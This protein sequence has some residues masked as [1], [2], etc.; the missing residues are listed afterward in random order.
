MK[1]IRQFAI[2]LLCAA[3]TGACA[4]AGGVAGLAGAARTINLERAIDLALSNNR[5][6]AITALDTDSASI[7]VDNARSVFAV[8]ARPEVSFNTAS[9]NGGSSTV[10]FN[11]SKRFETGTEVSSRITREELDGVEGARERLVV[12]VSQPLFRFSGRLVNEEPLVQARSNLVRAKRQL[13]SQKQDLVVDVVREYENIIRLEK[14]VEA[15]VRSHERSRTLYKS[16]KAKETLGRASRVDTLRVDLQRGQSLSRLESDRER[17]ESARRTFAE[18]LGFEPRTQ[19]RLAPTI[20]LNLDVPPLEQTVRV[21]LANRLDYAQALQDQWDA[22]RGVRIARKGLWPDVRVVARYEH[23]SAD[24]VE[25]LDDDRWF[26][27]LSADTDFNRTRQRNTLR[28]AG[29]D[30]RSAEQFSRLIELS[31]ARELQQRLLAYRRA[32][33]DLK[34]RERN[35]RYAEERLRLARRLFDIG[36]GDNF[37]VTDAEDAYVQAESQRLAARSDASITAYELLRA[38]GT[39]TEV[40]AELK[41]R[42]L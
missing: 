10:G 17:L 7:S 35:L 40:P 27:G 33:A 9:G 16:T 34:I 18:L 14:Q 19:F 26:V 32:A 15:D 8:S 31:I 25:G 42:Q 37:S 38:M 6:L 39:L 12:Q 5:L 20:P 11:T 30:A 29:I 36:R 21:A 1:R 22:R 23:L 3:A 4:A 2:G 13:E 41:P 24:P 28:Q